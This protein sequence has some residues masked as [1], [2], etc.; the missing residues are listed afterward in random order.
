[1]S[2]TGHGGWDPTA[3]I[4][5]LILDAPGQQGLQGGHSHTLPEGPPPLH[6]Y[7][8]VALLSQGGSKSAQVVAAG[9]ARAFIGEVGLQRG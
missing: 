7:P 5:C 9:G 3:A 8:E 6:S 2:S 1:M 4:V